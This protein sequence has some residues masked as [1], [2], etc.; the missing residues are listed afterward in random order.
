MFNN[1]SDIDVECSKCGYQWNTYGTNLLGGHACPICKS[2]TGERK[3]EWFLKKYKYKYIAQYSYNNCRDILPL[4][5]DFYLPEYNILIEIDGE[6]HYRPISFGCK[7]KYKILDNFY[8]QLNHDK[9]KN[10]YCK[11]NNIPLIR[12]PYYEIQDDNLEYF[13]FDMLKKHKAII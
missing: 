9:I 13:L 7:D 10:E 5:F 4:P 2:S 6:Q 11:R 1:Y 8:K 3:V 12:I